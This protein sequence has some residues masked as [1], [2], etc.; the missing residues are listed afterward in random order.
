M[1]LDLHAGAFQM[2]VSGERESL[3]QEVHVLNGGQDE[4]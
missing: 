2:P 1:P 4:P 3:A